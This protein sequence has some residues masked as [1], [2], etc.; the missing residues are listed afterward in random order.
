MYFVF[1]FLPDVHLKD[2]RRFS[3]AVLD[4]AAAKSSF[5]F[6]YAKL[7]LCSRNNL[8]FE[9]ILSV[10]CL[11]IALAATLG[12]SCISTTWCLRLEDTCTS[13]PCVSDDFTLFCL[14][15]MRSFLFLYLWWALRSSSN[16]LLRFS[17]HWHSVADT[18]FLHIERTTAIWLQK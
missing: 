16:F 1:I 6:I 18:F 10:E 8:S 7:S 11:T 9:Q 12:L 17:N 5:S 3:L 13:S 4:C 14:I 15:T 2:N